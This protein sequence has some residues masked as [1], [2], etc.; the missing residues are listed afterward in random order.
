[1]KY[2]RAKKLKK[3]K[4]PPYKKPVIEII[5][6]VNPVRELLHNYYEENCV[7][8]NNFSMELLPPSTNKLYE[9]SSYINKST[10]KSGLSVSLDD[11]IVY[12]RI[13]LKSAIREMNLKPDGIL[14]ILADFQTPTWLTKGMTPKKKDSDNM[15]KSLMD[16]IEKGTGVPDELCFYHHLFKVYSKTDKLVVNLY[17][18]RPEIFNY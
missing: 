17:E 14:A 10:G 11:D 2:P 8:K 1:M 13:R 3:I 5:N 15:I 4:K 12:F 6:G 7:S 16:A 9:K 18:L